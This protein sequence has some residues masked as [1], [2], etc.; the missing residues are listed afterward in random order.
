MQDLLKRLEQ[1]DYKPTVGDRKSASKLNNQYT[2]VADSDD[3][4]LET[5]YQMQELLPKIQ[6][7][8]N[9]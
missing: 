7:Y 4:V 1:K 3:T 5:L 2:K 8:F 6:G 9:R